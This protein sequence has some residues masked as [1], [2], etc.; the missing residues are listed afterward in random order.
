MDS[1]VPSLRAAVAVGELGS[2]T[3]AAN[4]LGLTPSAVSK[5]VSRLER[6]L[7]AR[8]FMRTTRRVQP[9]DAGR[10]FLER[11]RRVL[12]E[13]DAL[14]KELERPE[15]EPRG[16][17][18][19]T[20]PP[21]FGERVVVP[22]A[23]T[24]VE[25]WPGLR[26]SFDLSDRVA[27]LVGERFDIA[28][29]YTRAP[30]PTTWVARKIGE[31]R[32]VLCAAPSYLERS[33][34]PRTP[35]ELATHEHIVM[36]ANGRRFSTLN[37]RERPGSGRLTLLQLEGRVEV[38][39]TRSVI[40]AALAGAGIAELETYLADE[41]LRAGRLREV[42]HGCMPVERS[43]W[44]MHAPGP[45]VPPKVRAFVDAMLKAMR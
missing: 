15:L 19:I 42:L 29:R 30:S 2:F 43:I 38:D 28:V 41:H 5:L 1:Q 9:T 23:L 22:T 36:V 13:L 35:A 20:A 17:L 37:V 26:V 24:L 14:D 31:E 4:R 11:T 32:R 25:R 12:S 18:K 3:A 39:D 16:L 33:G 7:S 8:L 45:H 40:Q 6:R 44:V 34:V 21:V 10:G 27:D